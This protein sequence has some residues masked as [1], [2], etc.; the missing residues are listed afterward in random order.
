VYLRQQPTLKVYSFECEHCGNCCKG[1]ILTLLPHE[2][3][4]LTK[5]AQ[6]L[7]L[8]IPN[9]MADTRFIKPVFKLFATPCPFWTGD[10]CKIYENRP[11][12]CRAYPIRPNKWNRVL[13]DIN[14][15]WVKAVH[16][17]FGRSDQLP[18][19]SMQNEIKAAMTF[20]AYMEGKI[21]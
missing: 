3:P 14:C 6:K 7:N 12:I 17:D 16:S 13:L 2:V 15:S 1:N 11:L 10:R 20:T 5:L 8:P 9:I 19:N 18:L 21:F 4:K